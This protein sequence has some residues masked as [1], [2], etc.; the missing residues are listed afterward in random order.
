MLPQRN[1]KPHSQ[2][3][4]TDHFEVLGLAPEAPDQA[5]IPCSS[6]KTAIPKGPEHLQSYDYGLGK[7]LT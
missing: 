7:F 5:M 6:P 4:N 2:L 3:M 1:P